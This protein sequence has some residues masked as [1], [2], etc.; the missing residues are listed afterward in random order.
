MPNKSITGR[1]HIPIPMGKVDK[2]KKEIKR[3]AS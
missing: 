3:W 1:T 2:V